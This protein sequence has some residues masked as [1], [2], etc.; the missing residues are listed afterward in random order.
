MNKRFER[1][2][3]KAQVQCLDVHLNPT[4]HLSKCILSMGYEFMYVDTFYWERNLS[5]LIIID[6]RGREREINKWLAQ[7]MENNCYW[8]T[9]K[10][11]FLSMFLLSLLTSKKIVRNQ[12]IICMSKP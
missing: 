9:F 2:I 4:M 3:E 6:E 12:L 1:K 10:F 8:T 5:F 7:V 11:S